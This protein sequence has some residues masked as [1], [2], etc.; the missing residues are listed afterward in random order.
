MAAA[1]RL[2]IAAQGAKNPK[3]L[4]FLKSSPKKL[5]INGKWVAAKSGKTFESINPANEEVLAEVAEAGPEDIDEAVKAARKAFEDGPWSKTTPHQRT[6]LLLKVAEL[7]EK[8]REELAE[9]SALDNG[10]PMIGAQGVV[11]SA[12]ELFT[13]FAG[14]PTKIY[15]E[16]NPSA[17]D[18]FN[19]T[20]R[21]PIGVCGQIIPWNGPLMSASNKLAHALST[22]NTVVLKPAE[23]APLVVLR[24]G[25]LLL[26]A[27]VPEGVVN[28]VPGFG[29]VAGAALS[30]HPD[31][32]KIAFTGSTTTGKKI[33]EAS[34]ATLK[35]VSLELGGKSPHIIFADADLEGAL[36]FAAIGIFGNSGQACI[37]G[38]RIFVQEKLHDQFVEGMVKRAR[39]H[40]LGA[41]FEAGVTMGP[42]VSKVQHE[43]VLGYIESGKS[44]GAKPAAGGGPGAQPKGYFVQPTVFTGVRNDMKI[45]REEIFGPVA[46][47]LPFKDENDAVLQGNDTTYGLAAG[48]WTRDLS[49]AHKVARRLKAGT[50]WINCYIVLDFAMPFGGYKQSGQ[51]REFSNHS[52]EMYTQM[53]SVFVK[54]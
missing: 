2:E 24:L 45:A 41:Q 20:L 12:I 51:G 27:G 21:E 29:P 1:P 46:A 31:V 6:K 5:L 34:V 50:V 32:D 28:I 13:Y 10:A 54:L 18:M 49:R 37:A 9:L 19:Y 48:I 30:N 8:N 15:G 25:E 43:R 38:S 17:P 14:W 11:N 39:A 53:K 16:T 33:L 35:H 44:E 40:K 4:E 36:N 22:G 23:Q 47:V 42:V 3:T 52:I 7:L 26:E